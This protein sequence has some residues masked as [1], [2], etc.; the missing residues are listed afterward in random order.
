MRLFFIAST[1]CTLPSLVLAA[2]PYRPEI[3]EASSEAELAIA[4]FQLPDGF[5]AHLT[6][7]E[8]MLANPVAFTF[9]AKGRIYVCETFRQSRGVEDNRGHPEW[10]ADD[11]AAEQV[12][13]RLAMFKRH[14]GDEVN[15][16]TLHHDRIRLLEDVDG[17]GTVDRSTV[18]A[19][20]FN[21]VLDGTGAGVLAVENDVY[22]TCI[23][24]LW[25]LADHDGDGQAD[26]RNVLHAGFGVRVAFRGHDLHGLIRGPDGR[27]YFSIGDRGYHIVTKEG[28]V[29]ARP[30]TG[31]VF[32]CELDGSKLEE[33]AWGLRNPQELAFDDAGN[34]FTGDNNSDG[35]DQ[36]RLV[37]IVPGGDSGWRMYYQYLPDRGPWNRTH[38]W[39]PYRDD[40][41]VA[42]SQPAYIVPPIAN[43]ADGP[44]G[45]A[46]YPGVGLPDRYQ[47]H[48]FL[49]D[50][51]GTAAMS[52]I[53]AFT[54]APDGAGFA[55]A[56]S[57]QFAWSVLA[58]DVEF[59]PAGNLHILDW[60]HSWDGVAKGRIYRLDHQQSVASEHAAEILARGVEGESDGQLIDWLAHP[61]RQ[62]RY[63]AQF[64]L[65]ERDNVADLLNQT[66]HNLE[67]PQI[68]RTHAIWCVGQRVRTN[69][70]GRWGSFGDNEQADNVL[71]LASEV[72][73][74]LGPTGAGPGEE[75][76]LQMLRV[77]SDLAATS[78]ATSHR[79]LNQLFRSALSDGNAQ[80]KMFAAYGLGAVGLPEDVP[81]I[82][83]AL[84]A[85]DNQDPI[86]RHALVMG[87]TG[88][89]E[90]HPAAIAAHVAYGQSP[91]RLGVLLALA[92][93]EHRALPRMLNDPDPHLAAEAARALYDE[94]AGRATT[95]VAIESPDPTWP[96]PLL[97]RIVGAWH[98]SG[99]SLDADRLARE[100]GANPKMPEEIRTFAWVALTAWFD[101]P[102]IDLVTGRWAP[103]GARNR[104]YDGLTEVAHEA[105]LATLQDQQPAIV[106][107]ALRAAAEHRLAELA[108]AVRTVLFTKSRPAAT[109]VAALTTWK[110]LAT[111]QTLDRKLPELLESESPVLRGAARKVWIQLHPERAAELLGVVLDEGDVAEQQAALETLAELED[112]ATSQLLAAWLDRLLAGD[113]RP[114]I[115]LDLIEAARARQEKLLQEKLDL[116][117]KVRTS[118]DPVAMFRDC[119]VGGDPLQGREVFNS[120]EASC[121]RCHRLGGEGTAVGPDLTKIGADKSREYLLESIVDPNRKIAEGFETTV[122]LTDEG[123]TYV[124]IVQGEDDQT[125]RLL[126]ADQGVMIID[127]QQI[128]GRTHGLSGMP[129]DVVKQLTKDEIRDLIAY[130]STLKGEPA[131]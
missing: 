128:E 45:L 50:F 39:R 87:L 30:D 43:F 96:S 67:V 31:A 2:E 38:M 8:P 56:D 104:K 123:K 91:G 95:L 13:D 14:L 68:A 103:L 7:A 53:R 74:R 99:M 97:R 26:Q 62:V 36:A 127:K 78:D 63:A 24:N 118:D 33:V 11:L 79:A 121:R 71:Q 77:L 88:I 42:E 90:R 61:H 9:D 70:A 6:A 109:R 114:E 12:E 83:A 28:T 122:I 80:A 119:L 54:L 115:S 27:L 64:A 98:R 59:D 92:R 17:D 107:A 94:S 86:L 58:T 29:L 117:D 15:D 41:E 65:A 125:V 40:E 57:H 129:A 110:E 21:D 108:P 34:L 37:Q 82:L 47:N 76:W 19:D 52:G 51:R 89:G 126:H 25:K 112:E 102:D 23:P 124:G 32:R 35:G 69:E 131:P 18:Y 130:L 116:L 49:A 5:T 111:E 120:S 16:Y 4:S 93:L 60:V 75:D 73:R 10:L 48:F 22:Y 85:N 44:S 81:Q 84:D 101:P 46:Y 3:A 55:L 66:I 72:H 105:I 113:V 100:I 20:G 1:I 106:E